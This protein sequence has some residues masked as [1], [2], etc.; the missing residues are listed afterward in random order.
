MLLVITKKDIEK[1]VRMLENEYLK[2][3]SR[4]IKS[5]IID[6]LSVITAPKG[7]P[8]REFQV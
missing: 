3:N 8:H 4:N 2:K 7:I 5:K 1:I 6:L